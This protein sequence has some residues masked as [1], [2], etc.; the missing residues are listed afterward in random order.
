MNIVFAQNTMLL[1]ENPRKE[2]HYYAFVHN[3]MGKYRMPKLLT[4]L[5][6]LF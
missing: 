1:R 6:D 5:Y 4:V 3:Y 2:N